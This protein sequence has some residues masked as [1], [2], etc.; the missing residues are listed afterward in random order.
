MNAL[1][2]QVE[3][4]VRELNLLPAEENVVYGQVKGVPIL[5]KFIGTEEAMVLLIQIRFPMSFS[6]R[7]PT[8]ISYGPVVDAKLED[9]T[10]EISIE[11]KNV[12]WFTINDGYHCLEEGNVKT[13]LEDVLNGLQKVGLAGKPGCCHFCQNTPVPQATYNSGKVVQICPACLNERLNTPENRP[14]EAAEGATTMTLLSPIVVAV[15]A[16]GWAAAWAGYDALFDLFGTKNIRIPTVM[17]LFGMVL[18]G[19]AV[20][21]PVGL[22]LK[23]IGKRGAGLSKAFAIVLAIGSVVLG[24]VMYITWLI[25]KDYEIVSFSVAVQILPDVLLESGPLAMIIRLIAAIAAVWLAVSIGKPKAPKL[26]L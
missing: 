22:M 15:G 18:I 24:E 10:A 9:R 1:S 2:A 26:L 14:A 7:V 21:G 4:L 25:Y 23:M 13:L 20:G 16:L 12:V 17:F 11:D 5:I 6:D 8:K 19:G 3:D